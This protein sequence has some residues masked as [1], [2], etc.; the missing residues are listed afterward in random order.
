MYL[1][2]HF[3]QDDP[4]QLHALIDAA[5]LAT[6]IQPAGEETLVNHLPFM[7]VERERDDDGE[8]DAAGS[9]GMLV[10]HVARANPV[11]RELGGRTSI[12][13]FHGPQAYV[14]PNWYPGKQVHHKVVP[15]WNYV[16]VHARGV[17]HAIED[18]ARL[19]DIVGRLTR[20]HEAGSPQPWKVGDAPPEFI[21]AMLDAIVG[22][23]IPIDSLLGKWK[24]SQNRPAQDR[25]GV[26]RGLREKVAGNAVAALVDPQPSAEP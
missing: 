20:I 16:A 23:E 9:H 6:W 26:A 7:R 15:T 12:V 13:V 2:K 8:G 19:L 14:S 22:I 17:A 3:R 25:V 24:M 10:G 1:P 4:A 11:W 5:P 21:E 18:R